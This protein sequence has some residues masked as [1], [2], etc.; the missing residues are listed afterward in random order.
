MLPVT[1]LPEG[2]IC[3][4]SVF[5]YASTTWE[6]CATI[7]SNFRVFPT[8]QTFSTLYEIRRHGMAATLPV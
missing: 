5:L 6:P 1:L 4:D 8:C 7:V 2:Y 3:I